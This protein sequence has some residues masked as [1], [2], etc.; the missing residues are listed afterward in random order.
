MRRENL[1]TINAEMQLA[2]DTEQSMVDGLK[3]ASKTTLPP[4]L[5]L[6]ASQIFILPPPPPKVRIFQNICSYL[7]YVYCC[8]VS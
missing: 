7:Q 1:Q 4:K 6:N 2:A 5:Y 3:Y 8:T